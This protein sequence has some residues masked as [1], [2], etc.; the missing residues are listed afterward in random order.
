MNAK[1]FQD[2]LIS[3]L[4]ES[5]TPF[6]AVASMEK[7][8]VQQGFQ[9][10]V[11]NQ[12]WK[13]SPGKK[14]FLTRNQSSLIAFRLSDDNPKLKPWKMAGAHTDSPC[15]KVKPQGVKYEQGYLQM[16]VEIYGGAL[17][18][19]WFDRDLS[20]AGR[21]H[22]ADP[23]GN[24]KSCLL[25]FK[26]PIA[27]IPSLAIHLF[28]E[29]HENRTIN[30]QKELPPVLMRFPEGDDKIDF[31]TILLNEIKEQDIDQNIHTV[32]AHEIVCYDTQQ[33]NLVGLN[34]EWLASARL[35][36]LLSCYVIL[37]ALTASTPSSNAL[38]I[39][40]DHEEVGSQSEVGAQ[41]PWL[42]R[43]LERI[44]EDPESLSRS[45]ADSW[46][47]SCDN[48]HGVHPNYPEKHDPEH[49]PRLNAGPAIKV[50]ANQRYA[51]TSHTAAKFIQVC[52]QL[53]LPYQYF[54]SRSDIPC[55]S[56]IGPLTAAKIGIATLDV[57]LPTWGMHSI[58]EIGGTEDAWSLMKIL[59]E[60]FS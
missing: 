18:A 19:P 13:L 48:A 41:G 56:T 5:P 50:N 53:K 59:Q 55:G 38:I 34:Q 21:V 16:G 15:L 49:R 45:L 35:D 30:P 23:K 37:N 14:Y 57:G 3:F 47:I 27:Y 26:R 24:R 32:L 11:E 25:D 39:C 20:L 46:L 36:N 6:H 31:N 58:R 52:Q 60:I 2:D 51:T 33:P 40:N 54:V 28:R 22:Y 1:S 44:H 42:Q 43:V 4:A 29:V 8:L 12:P 9:P 10:L 7:I 17:L